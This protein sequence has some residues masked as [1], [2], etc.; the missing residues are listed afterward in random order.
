MHPVTQV[1]IL[2]F[3]A[4]GWGLSLRQVTVIVKLLDLGISPPSGRDF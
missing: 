2:N 3:P 1:H 4:F